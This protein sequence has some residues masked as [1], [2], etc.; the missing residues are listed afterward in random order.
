LTFTPAPT[1]PQQELIR[2]LAALLHGAGGVADSTVLHISDVARYIGRSPAL[3][4]RIARGQSQLTALD[5]RSLSIMFGAVDRG[6]L[7]VVKGVAHRSKAAPVEPAARTMP[8]FCIDLTGP[9]PRLR[10]L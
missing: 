9:T 3:V 6:D 1:L 5:Q 4:R 7:A 8:V 2:R 10:R